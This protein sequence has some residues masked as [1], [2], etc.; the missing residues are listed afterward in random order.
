MGGAHD[1]RLRVGK[2]HRPAI[3]RADADGNARAARD[4][5]IRPRPLAGF[6]RLVDHDRLGAMH[7]IGR[8]ELVGIDAERRHRARPVGKDERPLVLRSD[9][10][11]EA[12]IDPRRQATLA[13]EEAMA[14]AGEGKQRMRSI[15]GEEASHHLRALGD[16]WRG[17]P[18]RL[19]IESTERWW[20]GVILT[21]EAG[22]GDRRSRWRGRPR[23]R[24]WVCPLHHASHGPPPPFHGGGS[25]AST[26][27]DLL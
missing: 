6:P 23:C 11:I 16:S 8:G 7:L 25:A 3:G 1:A 15:R 17:E 24:A 27:E 10:A 26:W 19:V 5:G 20:K 4:D 2:K 14:D 13:R 22:E 21:R 18:R 12:R 9:A